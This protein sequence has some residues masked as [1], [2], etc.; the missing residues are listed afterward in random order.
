MLLG[1][2]E[3]TLGAPAWGRSSQVTPR[4]LVQPLT[5]KPVPRGGRVDIPLGAGCL[6][7]SGWGWGG[8]VR[9]ALPSAA[10]ALKT[11]SPDPQ[12]ASHARWPVEPRALCRHQR[13]LQDTY[14]GVFPVKTVPRVRPGSVT[15]R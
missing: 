4:S 12:L 7:C 2:E 11:L 13:Q 9:P 10:L 15:L 8:P 3:S 6:H 14:D 5:A 1:S